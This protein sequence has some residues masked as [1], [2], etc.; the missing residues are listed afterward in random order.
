MRNTVFI[1]LPSRLKAIPT[2]L[3]RRLLYALKNALEFPGHLAI[4]ETTLNGEMIPEAWVGLSAVKRWALGALNPPSRSRGDAR[5][6]KGV[7]EELKNR[8]EKTENLSRI[9]SAVSKATHLLDLLLDPGTFSTH[10]R[11]A[12]DGVTLYWLEEKGTVVP[13]PY[14]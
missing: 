11:Y 14:Y 9:R 6:Y 3:H 12:W 2:L 4:S 8:W 5:S 1:V 7:I 10:S 13:W